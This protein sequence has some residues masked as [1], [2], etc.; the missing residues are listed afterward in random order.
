[1]SGINRRQLLGAGLAVLGAEGLLLRADAEPTPYAGTLADVPEFVLAQAP[2]A[3]QPELK[4]T[5]D[6]I[7]GPYYRKGAPFRGKV[8]PPLEPGVV[9]L[10]TGRVWGHDTRKPLSNAR[11]DIWQAN[12]AGRYDND[13]PNSPPK[14]DVFV[15]RCR[16]LADENG[17]YEYETIHPGAYQIG[18]MAWRPAHIHYLIQAPG[19]KPLVTQLFF[20]GDKF[21]EKDEFIKKSLIIKLT[22]KKVGAVSYEV[23]AFDIVLAK[24]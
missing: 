24:A 1:M 5:E 13:D 3:V 11:L 10:I 2:A 6:C 4:P 7:L 23:G 9:L 15:N 19:Y 17:L 20:E 8:T 21:N 18:P 14:P 22:N 16:L 12:A